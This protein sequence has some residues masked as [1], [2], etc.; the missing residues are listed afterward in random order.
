MSNFGFVHLRLVKPYE[1]AFREARSAVGAR[2]I[3]EVAEVFES[4]PDAIGDCALVAGTTAASHRDLHLPLY[5][6]E[7][8]TRLMQ[9]RLASTPAALLFGSEKFG[10]SNEHMAFCHWLLRIP[11]R[12]EH[13]SMNLGQAAA[14]CLYELRRDSAA[15]E[16]RFPAP[17]RP[18]AA[19][20]DRLT[21]LLIEMLS[22]AGYIK[23]RT[24]GSAELKIRRLV[25]R[26]QMPAGDAESWLGIFRQI[27][28]KLNQP[29]PV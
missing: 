29:G 16:Q 3:L 22:H 10:L 19:D 21:V 12:E 4:L 25:R 24:A 6:L 11:T 14:L 27:L 17:D 9:E 2:H 5:R 26:L 20:E 23:E 15:A 13:G 28:W 18:S 7:P 1:V 8:A